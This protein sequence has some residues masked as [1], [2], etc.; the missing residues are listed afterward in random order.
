MNAGWMA[1]VTITGRTTGSSSSILVQ[2]KGP[3][4]PDLLPRP[5]TPSSHRTHYIAHCPASPWTSIPA[6]ISPA[7]HCQGNHAA[8]QPAYTARS[9]PAI[10]HP[11]ST[12]RPSSVPYILSYIPPFPPLSLPLP[13]LLFLSLTA[14]IALSS[15]SARHVGILTPGRSCRPAHQAPCTARPPRLVCVCVYVCVCVCV[16]VCVCVCVCVC[17]ACAP[18]PSLRLTIV[19]S[20][21]RA[22]LYGQ[23][24]ASILLDHSSARPHLAQPWS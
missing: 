14:V 17:C 10:R 24:C 9:Q 1:V 12:I 22:L 18:R 6:H 21:S 15:L 3:P 19:C 7:R 20:L 5:T 11:P 16:Y 2:G 8:A 23:A 4:L 13:S